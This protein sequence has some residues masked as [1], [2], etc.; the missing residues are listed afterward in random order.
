MDVCVLLEAR[1]GGEGLA[2]LGAGVAAGARVLRADVALQVGRIGK[3]LQ[4]RQVSRPLKWF[5]YSL[6]TIS[7]YTVEPYNY[8]PRHRAV[9]S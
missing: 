9:N 7:T 6:I 1:G 5:A 4:P 8:G 3:Y 2:A